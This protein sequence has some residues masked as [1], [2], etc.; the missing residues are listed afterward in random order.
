MWAFDGDPDTAAT[1]AGAASTPTEVAAVAVPELVK[2][3]AAAV[4]IPAQPR[5]TPTA[6][7]TLLVFMTSPVEG[8]R[9]P[10]DRY[11]TVIVTWGCTPWQLS[12]DTAGLLM[13]T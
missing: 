4:A 12:C 1:P 5:A 10:P 7:S 13:E 8:R 11:V 2:N 9:E 3:A 6:A